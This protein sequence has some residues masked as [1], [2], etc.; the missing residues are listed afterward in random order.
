MPTKLRQKQVPKAR[1]RL[2]E[3]STHCGL[4]EIS[5]P[6]LRMPSVRSCP[7]RRRQHRAGCEPSAIP[8]V[9][10]FLLLAL[11]ARMA[12]NARNSPPNSGPNFLASRAAP[13][14]TRPPKLKRITYSYHFARFRPE[15]LTDTSIV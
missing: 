8:A 10:A 15:V 4:A 13:A 14:V 11:A 5:R 12:G 3:R 2:A 1:L 7:L 9:N 6:E